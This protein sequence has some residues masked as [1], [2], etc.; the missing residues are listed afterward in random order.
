MLIVCNQKTHQK[1]NVDRTSNSRDFLQNGR[2][3]MWTTTNAFISVKGLK[4]NYKIRG[5]F[6]TSLKVNFLKKC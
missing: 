6:I 5:Q 3:K 1:T 2:Q 4:K